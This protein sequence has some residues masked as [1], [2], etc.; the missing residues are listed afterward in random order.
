MLMWSL[1]HWNW[2]RRWK[3]QMRLLFRHA[4]YQSFW[5]MIFPPY[6]K[7][8][9]DKTI[10][11]NSIVNNVRQTRSSRNTN[12]ELAHIFNNQFSTYHNDERC[13][14]PINF[15]FFLL[16]KCICNCSCGS[17]LDESF[18]F[19][20]R[21]VHHLLYHDHL[22]ALFKVNETY[23]FYIIECTWKDWMSNAKNK[24]AL[25]N[26]KPHSTRKRSA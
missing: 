10:H 22:I 12:M 4:H 18:S 19:F 3:T 5:I 26:G 21:P 15:V 24:S 16:L 17:L 23:S 8:Q 13:F 6:H 7:P 25:I 20:N 11:L 2:F 14:K 1:K 9:L